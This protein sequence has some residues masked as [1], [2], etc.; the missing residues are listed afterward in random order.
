MPNPRPGGAG[1]LQD[2]S[3]PGTA[4]H[5]PVAPPPA[6]GPHLSVLSRQVCRG[7]DDPHLL[8]V[9]FLLTGGIWT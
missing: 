5:C 8:P 1:F 3:A 4:R 6:T 2:E 7:M 9:L